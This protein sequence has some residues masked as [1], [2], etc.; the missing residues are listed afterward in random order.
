[1]T[2]PIKTRLGDVNLRKKSAKAYV[3]HCDTSGA[4]TK[5]T[6]LHVAAMGSAPVSRESFPIQFAS[7]YG[8]P[9]KIGGRGSECQWKVDEGAI[10]KI[11]VNVRRGHG[12]LPH[13]GFIYMKARAEAPYR[14]LTFD[15]LDSPN[16]TLTEAQ[17]E[18]NFDILSVEDAELEGV[19]IPEH[20]KKLG[21]QFHRDSI[22]SNDTIIN[23]AKS[24]P[25]V[26]KRKVIGDGVKEKVVIVKKRRRSIG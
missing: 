8:I 13:T 6:F 24:A 1:M 4:K 17:V 3:F 18:G 9:E 19:V 14:R 10:L 22:L 23:A 15:L 16:V 2:I 11:S 7:I 21:D 25:L 12:K 5:E 26:R 20:L